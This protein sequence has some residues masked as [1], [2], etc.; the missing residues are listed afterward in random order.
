[1]ASFRVVIR[2]GVLAAL[3][4]SGAACLPLDAAQ[5]WSSP[6]VGAACKGLRG[7]GPVVERVQG[8]FMG[9]RRLRTIN[10]DRDVK[11][12]QA[13]FH[14]VQACEHWLQRKSHAYPLGPAF[15][16]CTVVTLR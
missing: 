12:F 1:M 13:C 14:T 3:L 4:V 5:A 11:S 9:A 6:R 2:R 15:A 10:T 7:A 8:N 16:R